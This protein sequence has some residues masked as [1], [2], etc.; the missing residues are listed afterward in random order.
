MECSMTARLLFIGM[1]NFADDLGRLPL[2]AKTIKAQVFPSDDINSSTILGMVEELSRNGLVLR[3]EVDGREYLQITGWQHQR[4]D[5]PQPGKCPSPINGYSKTIPGMVATEGKGEE[6]K[7]KEKDSEPIGSGADAPEPRGKLFSEGLQKLAELTGKGPD[8]CR[9]FVG[10]CLKQVDDDASIVMGVIDDAHRNRIADAPAW[11]SRAL[12]S[13]SSSPSLSSEVD[14]ESVVSTFA[15]TKHW[16]RW[17][18]PDPDSPA[19]RAPPQLLEKYGIKVDSI[20]AQH[21]VQ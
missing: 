15:R 9:S 20:Q 10:K 2:S 7:V 13:R 17:A 8:S 21:R 5:K 1:W 14:W 11:I 4:I 6:G 12:K 3:Y 19:C 16:S 18:G